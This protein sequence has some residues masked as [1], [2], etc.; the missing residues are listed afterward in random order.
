MSPLN[1]D[2]SFLLLRH[3][4]FLMPPLINAAISASV[5]KTL[6][7]SDVTSDQCS[8]FCFCCEDINVVLCHHFCFFAKTLALSPS[9]FSQLPVC[10]CCFIYLFFQILS[11]FNFLPCTCTCNMYNPVFFVCFFLKFILTWCLDTISS[12]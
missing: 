7:F 4:R 6:A 12:S 2:I 1:A 9:P 5:A 11:L 3:W 8:N 10:F